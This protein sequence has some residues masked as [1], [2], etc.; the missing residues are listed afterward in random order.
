MKARYKISRG[1]IELIKRFE[2]LN[3]DAVRLADGRWSIGYGHTL[4][5]REGAKISAEDADALLRFDLLPVA[6]A[7]STLVHTDLSQSQFDALA[8]FCFNVGL[9]TFKQ[10]DVIKQVNQGRM[11]D[12]AQALD[13]W[14]RSDF[15]GQ[16][17]VLEPL[18]RRR[19]AEKA[20]FLSE[21]PGDVAA[22]P[23]VRPSLDRK[24][25]DVVTLY[26][27]A[28]VE[29]VLK[30]GV[31]SAEILGLPEPDLHPGVNQTPDE[32]LQEAETSVLPVVVSL[33]DETQPLEIGVSQAG[34][35]E[36]KIL[37]VAAPVAIVPVA[38][39]PV[40]SVPGHQAGAELGAE[41][42]PEP[43]PGPV[44]ETA[45]APFGAAAND[46]DQAT[47][48]VSA[49]LEAA[50]T[51]DPE[52]A[53]QSLVSA[54]A[55]MVLEAQKNPSAEEGSRFA[56]SGE[57]H[58]DQAPAAP[59]VA[60]APFSNSPM[61]VMMGRPKPPQ[62]LPEVEVQKTASVIDTVSEPIVAPLRQT[63]YEEGTP[64][65]S[66]ADQV[67][68]V[69]RYRGMPGPGGSMLGGFGMTMNIPSQRQGV[70]AP[71][72]GVAVAGAGLATEQ[73]AVESDPEPAPLGGLDLAPKP[74]AEGETAHISHLTETQGVQAPL[75]RSSPVAPTALGGHLVEPEIIYT[76]DPVLLSPG[77]GARGFGGGLS[78]P[79]VPF[80]RLAST[81]PEP[82]P[83]P[84]SGL[85]ASLRIGEVFPTPLGA[86]AVSNKAGQGAE[87]GPDDT[88]AIQLFE[89]EDWATS[90]LTKTVVRPSEE[91]LPVDD[92]KTAMLP[93][94][95]TAVIGMAA[96]A[97]AVASYLKSK[98][99]TAPPEN[100]LDDPSTLTL[101]LG[102]AT[103][104]LIST[105]VYFLL[106]RLGGAE[107]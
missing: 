102:L 68:R 29:T 60:R 31:L 72:A 42:E 63:G 93:W 26:A 65:P 30:D 104:G 96:F 100:W 59:K 2:S 86:E 22:T 49:P 37:D 84:G 94:L 27:P 10:S 6:E 36:A 77:H 16:S 40:A 70:S 28:R 64:S 52:L 11:A 67:V 15:A 8:S 13:A 50:Q 89:A 43:E 19:A 107:S 74:E 54:E 73:V 75:E 38:T 23:L 98:N 45:I 99:L 34:A 44:E 9:E 5:A 83:A 105:S 79:S 95:L 87:D 92:P 24:L 25:A 61:Q 14:R 18:M 69:A 97:G 41:P 53:D 21:A 57:I 7:V 56:L 33:S 85:G 62:I 71:R 76:D 91:I 46:L 32:S 47:P 82:H 80:G 1:G 39:V 101:L 3:L 81:R 12:A 20:L 106:K 51:T 58:Q 17:Y 78:K 48:A 66:T 90:R 103:V 88:L 35:A 55:D 4:S